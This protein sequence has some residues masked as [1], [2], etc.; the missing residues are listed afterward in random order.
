[1]GAGRTNTSLWQKDN[2]WEMGDV[3]PCG[4]CSEIHIDLRSDEEREAVP[5]AQLVNQ[6]HPQ[7]VEIWNLVFI[8]Y[9]RMQDGH[10][11]ALP[12]KHVDTGMGFERLCMAL[13]GK[14]SNYD[15]DIF[16]P[17]IQFIEAQTGVTY[18]DSYESSAKSDVAMRVISD[19]MCGRLL[20]DC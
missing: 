15:T 9:N 6:D 16:L 5:A 11:E 19:H 4:P 18:T 17:Y 14:K 2:F 7:V 8:Q 3:G 1:M 13:Q 12:S 20:Y 10:L